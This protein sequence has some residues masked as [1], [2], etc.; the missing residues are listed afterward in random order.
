MRRRTVHI[1]GIFVLIIALLTSVVVTPVVAAESFPMDKDDPEIVSALQYL[2]S[3]QAADGSVGSY[4]DSAWVVMAI[5]AAK[6]IPE[7][8][9]TNGVSIVDYL[10]NNANQAAL[11]FR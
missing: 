6:M 4:G 1:F 11:L 2:R 5:A 10:K 9:E 3:M 8:W 7:Q